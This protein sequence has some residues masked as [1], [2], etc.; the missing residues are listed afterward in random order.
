MVFLAPFITPI[1]TTLAWVARVALP[2]VMS[3]FFI[4]MLF[5]VGLWVLYFMATGVAVNTMLG[6]AQGYMAGIPSDVIQIMTLTGIINAMNIIASA[7]L[8]KLTLKIDAV[9]LVSSRES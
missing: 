1:I 9:K 3:H 5:R 8:F 4:G 6:W 7:Y 2:A